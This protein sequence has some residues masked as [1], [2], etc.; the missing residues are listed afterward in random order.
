M[1]ILACKIIVSLVVAIPSLVL[2]YKI[3]IRPHVHTVFNASL[4]CLFCIGGVF[5]PLSFWWMVDIVINVIYEEMEDQ[6]D[7]CARLLEVNHLLAES[8][9][10]ITAN[11]MFRFFYIVYAN[12]G[13]VQ[14]GIHDSKLFKICFIISTLALTISN[15]L[16]F[17]IDK[18]RDRLYPQNTVVGRIC[19]NIRLDSSKDETTQLLMAAHILSFGSLYAYLV[20]RVWK[21]VPEICL[22]NSSHACLG[23]KYRRNI[24]TF[25]ELSAWFF[26]N[27]I[28][29]LIA[30]FLIHFLHKAQDTFTEREVF[31]IY[32]GY[33]AI[34]NTFN[35]VVIPI[36]I[37]YKSRSNYPIIWS[38]YVVKDYK[39]VSNFKPV[40]NKLKTIRNNEV[41]KPEA[42]VHY[43]NVKEAND[44][45]SLGLKN[46]T[47]SRYL[48]KETHTMLPK[49][50]PN[51]AVSS[52]PSVEI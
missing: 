15:Y 23:G 43:V 26:I 29:F 27:I 45:A 12:R 38:N 52:L 16:A 21:F 46:P 7:L 30:I 1:F 14:N 2:A 44:K 5:G 9:K 22:S 51:R 10:I 48:K 3:I 39:F 25:N 37:L 36:G 11:I 24:L 18:A 50:G 17:R 49:Q 40:I 6:I 19:L 31:Y 35:L 28:Q 33:A 4:A 34:H 32:I 47:C 13:L 41:T 20:R 42:H 8:L